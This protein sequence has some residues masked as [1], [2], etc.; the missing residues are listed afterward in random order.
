MS[1]KRVLTKEPGETQSK[2]LKLDKE[3]LTKNTVKTNTNSD[4]TNQE[5]ENVF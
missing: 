1:E 5:I 3:T 4:I 2:K